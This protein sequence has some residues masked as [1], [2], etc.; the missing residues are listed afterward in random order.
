MLN[1]PE[2]QIQEAFRS[3]AF[4]GIRAYWI[5]NNFH[6][7][8]FQKGYQ[9]CVA[10]DY[11]G[12]Q[13]V[14]NLY[15]LTVC[16]GQAV[17]LCKKIKSRDMLVQ[18]NC[19]TVHDHARP[20]C[21]LIQLNGFWWNSVLGVFILKAI[22]LS[23]MLMRTTHDMEHRGRYRTLACQ[24]VLAETRN[25]CFLCGPCTFL[26][27]EGKADVTS[28]SSA[29]AFLACARTNWPLHV[30]HVGDEN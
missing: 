4:T 28:P 29:C 17:F 22:D 11:S 3:N 23:S 24:S 13:E 9:V 21:H 25:L 19:K 27:S 14:T 1:F 7:L 5:E 18:V 20:Q 12:G 6:F 10:N 2:G 15:L 26:V 16:K 8:R 30:K